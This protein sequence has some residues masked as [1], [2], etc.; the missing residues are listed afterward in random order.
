MTTTTTARKRSFLDILDD[1]TIGRCSHNCWKLDELPV[2]AQTKLNQSFRNVHKVVKN[3]QTAI[4]PSRAELAGQWGPLLK[5]AV[6][7]VCNC[8]LTGESEGNDEAS[9]YSVTPEKRL[10]RE[11]FVAL[12]GVRC[13]LKLLEPPFADRDARTTP[14]SVM[15]ERSEV[16]KEALIVFREVCF[17]SSYVSREISLANIQYL[18]SLLSHKTLFDCTISVLEE[19]LSSPNMVDTFDL[20]SLR[21]ANELFE[22]FST[23]QLVLMC[24][25]LSLVLFEP[26][27]RM[28]ME[29]A[30]VRS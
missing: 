25:V 27:D 6:Q 14:K 26:E 18:L 7:G 12:G 24:R 2:F 8:L 5:S 23:K 10:Q 16:L 21:G 11:M 28:A 19:I 20:T 1:K 9:L 22:S 4:S 13:L 17:S 30:T 3:L 29:S 15:Y